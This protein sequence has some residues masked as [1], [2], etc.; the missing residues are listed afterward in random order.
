MVEFRW[1]LRHNGTIQH[2][3]EDLARQRLDEWDRAVKSAAAAIER[4]ED[5]VPRTRWKKEWNLK[6][7]EKRRRSIERGEEQK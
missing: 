6:Q 3:S 1:H 7:L 5:N 2:R 4:W